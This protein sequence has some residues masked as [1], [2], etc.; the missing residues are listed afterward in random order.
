MYSSHVSITS[1]S[2][3]PDA[4]SAVGERCGHCGA[5]YGRTL[6]DV[7]TQQA[8]RARDTPQEV[9]VCTAIRRRLPEHGRSPRP[10]RSPRLRELLLVQGGCVDEDGT[11]AEGWVCALLSRVKGHK[12]LLLDEHLL[13]ETPTRTALGIN[14]RAGRAMATGWEAGPGQ[15]QGQGPTRAVGLQEQARPSQ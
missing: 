6:I 15:G 1:A 11:V 13:R 3:W 5:G 14:R 10:G 9:V 7:S 12:R 2:T 4:H 8:S